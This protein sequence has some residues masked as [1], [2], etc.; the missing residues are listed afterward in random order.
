MFEHVALHPGKVPHLM[1]QLRPPVHEHVESLQLHAWPVHVGC[2]L[3]PH[4]KAAI[5]IATEAVTTRARTMGARN[6]IPP[7]RFL[8]AS[9]RGEGQA[10]GDESVDRLRHL[11]A[12]DEV[13]G[14]SAPARR[15]LGA[16]G[17]ALD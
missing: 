9:S 17:G 8:L 1:S 13:R 11:Q 4:A 5:A 10:E 2:A 12:G 14:R 3:G 6:S 7:T 15:S 16:L